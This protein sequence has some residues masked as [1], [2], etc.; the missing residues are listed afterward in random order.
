MHV[1]NFAIIALFSMCNW[2]LS[3]F[4]LFYWDAVN[5][6]LMTTALKGSVQV[7]VHDLASHV[8]V[9]ETTGHDKYVGIIVLTDKVCNLRYPAESGADAL[10]LVQGH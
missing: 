8:G 7:L 3:P 6:S 5:A 4:V 2:G 9:D 1:D 10:M